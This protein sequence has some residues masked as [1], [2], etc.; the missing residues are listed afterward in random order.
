[1]A[2]TNWDGNK[3][4]PQPVTLFG[5]GYDV[6][7]TANQANDS[8]TNAFLSDSADNTHVLLTVKAVE[9]DLSLAGSR[10]QSPLQQ[11]FYPRNFQ[12]PSFTITCQARSQAEIGRIS[13]FVHKA[14]RN[15]VSQGSLMT[16]IIPAGGLNHTRNLTSSG[17]NSMRGTRKGMQITGY[18]KSMPRSHRRHD[19]APTFA[20]DFVVA[21]MH[22]G[23]FQDQPYKAYKLASWSEIVDSVLKDNFISPPQTVDQEEQKEATRDA[24]D[25]VQSIPFLGD[26][27]GGNTLGRLP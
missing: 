4:A 21:R 9:T 14:Q 22:S 20:F 7:T 26:L 18:V 11:D 12:Q 19:P 24:A 8:G 17:R 25:A 6:I 3:R 16:L 10:G 13:E 15:S 1:M 27:L 5:K 23:V 2:T